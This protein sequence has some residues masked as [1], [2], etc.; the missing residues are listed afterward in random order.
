MM[1]YF[2]RWV[3]TLECTMCSNTLQQTDV[4]LYWTIIK[5]YAAIFL[6]KDQADVSLPPIFWQKI[7]LTLACH[8]SFGNTPVC[9]EELKMTVRGKAKTSAAV[10]RIQVEI[11]SGPGALPGLSLLSRLITPSSS[12]TMSG[13]AGMSQE[14]S[15]GCGPSS[16]SFVKTDL[17]FLV[18]FWII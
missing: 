8:Q 2:S 18:F 7:G 9:R 11:S 13:I 10:L 5:R 6:F 3:I 15:A 12:M 16:V 1:R 17:N 14:V 4:R